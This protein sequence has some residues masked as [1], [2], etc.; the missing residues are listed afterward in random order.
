MVAVFW[1]SY[2]SHLIRF[3]TE[4]LT[5]SGDYSLSDLAWPLPLKKELCFGF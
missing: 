5:L 3:L 4:L 2:S 1:I